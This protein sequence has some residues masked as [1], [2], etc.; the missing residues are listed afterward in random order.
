VRLEF[1]AKQPGPAIELGAAEMEFTYSRTFG[2]ER[3]EAYERLLHDALLGDRTLFT[4]ADGI[5]RTWEVVADVLD[6]PPPVQRYE[7]GSWGPQAAMDL[8]APRTWHL[9]DDH[10]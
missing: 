4:R 7:Q 2:T 1:L 6:H 8:I 5:G 10:R 9:P 3:V